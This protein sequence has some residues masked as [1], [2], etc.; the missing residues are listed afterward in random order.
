MFHKLFF[1]VNAGRFCSFC[2][3]FVCVDVGFVILIIKSRF[4]PFV[5][6]LLVVCFVCCVDFCVRVRFFGVF[7]FCCCVVVF[8]C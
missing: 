3:V 2:L 5:V 6:L 4:P 1:G 7:V 8:V